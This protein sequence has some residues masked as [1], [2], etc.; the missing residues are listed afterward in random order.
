MTVPLGLAMSMSAALCAAAAGVAWRVAGAR[1]RRDLAATLD[2]VALAQGLVLVG[3]DG[4]GRATA[5]NDAAARM[6]G[7]PRESVL[8]RALPDGF[9]VLPGHLVHAGERVPVQLPRA[10]GGDA[11]LSATVIALPA[12]GGI[13]LVQ[14]SRHVRSDLEWEDASRLQRDSLIR[15]VH[16]RIKNSL[17]GVA[18]LLRQHLADKP[19]LRPLLE[20]VTTQVNAIAA[21]H[22]LQGEATGGLVNLR[23]L[24]ARIAAS[25]S[26]TMHE[27]L[28]LSQ[29]CAALDAFIVRESESVAIAIVLNE[30]LVNAAKHRAEG[31]GA[32]V[33]D[34]GVDATRVE[35]RIRNPGFLPAGFDLDGGIRIGNGLALASSLLPRRGVRI[36]LTDDGSHV[37]TTMTL[38]SPD[39]LGVYEAGTEA[40]R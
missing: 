35:L 37:I 11:G 21:V 38:L 17:Q 23:M 1:A 13:A 10:D 18:G 22:G 26:G 33:L 19:L 27:P 12:G 34:A 20:A 30:L 36:G 31:G 2:A 39:V 16:H 32:I 15:E 4:E 5:W 29:Q 8:G 40:M 9:D 14:A 6:F 7:L 24:V 28:V 3:W 25:V